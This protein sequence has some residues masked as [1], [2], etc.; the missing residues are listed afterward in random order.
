MREK[1]NLWRGKLA[2]STVAMWNDILTTD[3]P[4]LVPRIEIPTYFMSGVFDYTVSG[5]LAK[6]YLDEI[7]APVKGFFWFDESAH[8][9]MFEEPARFGRILRELGLAGEHTASGEGR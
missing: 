8:S 4:A 6:A 9:P 3:L 2:P 5:A 7:E 1:I